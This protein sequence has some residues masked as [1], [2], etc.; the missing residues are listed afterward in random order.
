MVCTADFLV[1]PSYVWKT[2]FCVASV[3]L[4]KKKITG[5][6]TAVLPHILLKIHNI[7]KVNYTKAHILFYLSTIPCMHF[8]GKSATGITIR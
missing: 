1:L 2:H 5:P 3:R 8:T 4:G 6:Y 7:N